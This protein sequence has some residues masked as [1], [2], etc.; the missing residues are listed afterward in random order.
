RL[1]DRLRGLVT[2]GVQPVG[3]FFTNSLGMKFAWIPAGIF[4]M[5]SPATEELRGPDETPHEVT[6]TKG[7][8]LAVHP[9]T[10]GAWRTIMEDTPSYYR[11]DSRP[12]EQVSWDACQ[13]F[14]RKLSARDGNLYRLPTEAE[15][16]YACR[17]GTTSPFYFGGTLSTDQANYL[18]YGGDYA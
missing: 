10:Q 17:A 15:W 13:E 6:L 3:P 5:G 2:A 16:E 4:L 11:D 14:L 9:V 12:V 1:E 18:T 7:Y 8:Y